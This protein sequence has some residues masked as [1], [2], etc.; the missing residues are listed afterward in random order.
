M[1]Y[2]KFDY[3]S[4]FEKFNK[5]TILVIGDVMLDTYL[6]GDVKRISPEAPVP[7]CNIKEKT[8]KLGGAAN[9]ALNL[10]N[11]GAIPIICSVI[12]HDETSDAFNQLLKANNLNNQGIYVSNLRKTTNKTR[13]IGNKHQL[14]R[15]DDETRDDLDDIS[16]FALLEIIKKTL[17]DNKIDGIVFEDYDKGI[18]SYKL[19]EAVLQL[20][21]NKIRIYVDPK[22][23][24][25][26]YYH[27]IELFKPNLTEFMNGLKIELDDLKT[28]EIYC[29][30]LHNERN[31]RKIMIT[32]AE[33]GIFI[34]IKNGNAAYF[35]TN[36]KNIVDVSG[37]GDSVI[38]IST[39]MDIEGCNLN[40]TAYISNIAGGL[41]CENVGVTPINKEKILK[42]IY[43]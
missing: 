39:L 19:I 27:D 36:K 2:K 31:I 30:K 23:K 14:L 42:E 28:L 33:R 10:Q 7:I 26:N 24:N 18:I 32:M 40:F 16:Y 1:N 11:L 17:K 34:S 3:Y 38:A 43:E 35:P 22:Y 9:V 5:N 25:F 29:Q 37:A 13:V 20:T 6:I 21:Q 12:G 15:I 8:Y 41:A 4:V